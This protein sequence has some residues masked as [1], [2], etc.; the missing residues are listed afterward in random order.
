MVQN[1]SHSKYYRVVALASAHFACQT[2]DGLRV[3][4]SDLKGTEQ[5]GHIAIVGS[6][7]YNGTSMVQPMNNALMPGLEM[8]AAFKFNS[9]LKNFEYIESLQDTKQQAALRRMFCEGIDKS[10]DTV[11]NLFQK[12]L[13]SYTGNDLSVQ[14][15]QMLLKMTHD[16]RVRQVETWASNSG[17]S[18]VQPS[19]KS[20][21][22]GSSSSN[23][24]ASLGS[25][26]TTSTGSNNSGAVAAMREEERRTDKAARDALGQINRLARQFGLPTASGGQSTGSGSGTSSSPSFSSGSTS[27]GGSSSVTSASIL[28]SSSSTGT[29][30]GQRMH[31]SNVTLDVKQAAFE[32]E[33]FAAEMFQEMATD[34]KSS[35]P[36]KHN[37][38]LSSIGIFKSFN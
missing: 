19:F 28:R 34:F 18:F 31:N 36:A 11:N 5:N 27:T 29:S 22:P 26:T 6:D 32:T 14:R 33:K 30:I 24:A 23:C 10:V 12:N 35:G 37:R 7:E 13:A 17:S 4:E 9:M 8:A 15:F 3:F 2:V 20:S 1:M 21:S 16:D 38:P 25:S